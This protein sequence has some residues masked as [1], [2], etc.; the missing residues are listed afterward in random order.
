MKKR[1][2][3]LIELLIVIAIIAIL[4]AM[5]LP[6][7]NK[8]REK[9]RSS[10][11]LSQIRQI[12]TAMMIYKDDHEDYYVYAGGD[13]ADLGWSYTMVRD[14]YITSPK[15]YLCP[16]IP[17]NFLYRDDFTLPNAASWTYTWISYGYNYL[18][19]GSQY[20][21][22]GSY[23]TPKYGIKG[24]MVRNPSSIIMLADSRYTATIDRGY[25]YISNTCWDSSYLIHERH[26]QKNANIGWTDGHVSSEVKPM[27]RFQVD[28][29]EHINPFYRP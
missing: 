13:G 21:R 27:S 19:L 17:G 20:Y 8:A 9:A 23:S 10:S 4:A 22:S 26:G 7:L 28:P 12:S 18:G 25:Y 29:S 5:L 14:K 3:T 6:A 15:L 2:F 24:T 16:S 1:N 11:C